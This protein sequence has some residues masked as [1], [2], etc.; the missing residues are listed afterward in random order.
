MWY[1]RPARPAA[2]PAPDQLTLHELIATQPR[3]LRGPLAPGARFPSGLRPGRRRAQGVDLD[4]IAPY[5]P[6]DD[7]R[8][9][10]WRATARTGRAQMK[11]FA[12]E[13]HLAR[14]L[15]VDMRPQ[16]FF[17]T[18][19]CPMAKTAALVAARFSWEALSLHEAVGLIVVPTAEV[20]Q[21]RR[22]KGHVLHILRRLEESY[23]GLKEHR[24]MPPGEELARAL[25]TAA[26]NLRHGDEICAISDFG[27]PDGSLAAVATGLGDTRRLCAVIIEDAVFAEP[28]PAGRYPIQRAA[29]DGRHSAVVS[30]RGAREQARIAEEIRRSLRLKLVRSGWKTF[31]AGA[32]FLRWESRA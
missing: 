22:G 2:P 19:N 5:V 23:K 26:A 16:L 4:S 15:I 28:V 3:F 29:G 32:D 30:N 8:W 1:N 27:G 10:D 7:V 9:M 20:M 25:E 31:M 21:P 17:G 18:R 13:S 24:E 11:R 14:M 6:G 12:A